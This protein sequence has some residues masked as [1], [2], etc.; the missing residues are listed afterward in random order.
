MN[1]LEVIPILIGPA[2]YSDE[3]NDK[4]LKTGNDKFV[5][6]IKKTDKDTD[7]NGFHFTASNEDYEESI[8]EDENENICIQ[9]GCGPIEWVNHMTK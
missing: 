4:R 5:Q 2:S 8:N 6:S 7:I 3:T 9:C 1:V